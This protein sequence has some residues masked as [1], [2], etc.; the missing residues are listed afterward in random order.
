[1]CDSAARE[2]HDVTALLERGND[3]VAVVA[4]NLDDAALD[5]PARAAKALELAGKLLLLRLGR[6]YAVYGR[7]GLAAPTARLAAHA[8]DAVAARHGR[9]GRCRL[10]PADPGG[11]DD[12]A[13]A[14]AHRGPRRSDTRACS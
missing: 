14:R 10:D 7:D 11:I 1:M 6:H 5:G 12:S 8:H 13:V 2:L 4:L 3:L 9:L